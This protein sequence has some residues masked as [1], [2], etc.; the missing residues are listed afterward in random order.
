MNE[1]DWE[2]V[3][4]MNGISE[5]ELADQIYVAAC[6]MGVLALDSEDADVLK[7]K[8]SDNESEIELTV[9]RVN[10]ETAH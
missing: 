2:Q 3:A 10:S 9:R 4:E 6:A 5:E 8:C 7:F 1:I